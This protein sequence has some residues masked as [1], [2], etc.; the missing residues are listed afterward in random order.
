VIADENTAMHNDKAVCFRRRLPGSAPIE[1][2][3]SYCAV[4]ACHYIDAQWLTHKLQFH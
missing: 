4:T 3:P 2:H 1:T